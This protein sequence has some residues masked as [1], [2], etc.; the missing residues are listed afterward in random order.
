VYVYVRGDNDTG[1]IRL[2]VLGRQP[3]E[4]HSTRGELR[5]HLRGMLRLSL[6]IALAKE[7]TTSLADVVS[8]RTLGFPTAR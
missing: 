2:S 1:A 6:R 3:H 4:G 8:G 7:A 5:D